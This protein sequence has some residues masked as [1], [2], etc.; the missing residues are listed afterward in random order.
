MEQVAQALDTG[1]GAVLFAID[2]EYA[3]FWCP[4]CAAAYCREHY[5]SF[6]VYDEGFFDCIRGVCPK[7][8]E[9]TLVD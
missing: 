9:R 8:H 6:T 1:D 5:R 2:Q 3:P 4:R 7:G